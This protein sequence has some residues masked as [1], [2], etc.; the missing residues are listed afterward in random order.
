VVPRAPGLADPQR[1]RWEDDPM[2]AQVQRA[3]AGIVGTLARA[4]LK[5]VKVTA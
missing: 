2:T 3:L 4:N 5:I 1:L